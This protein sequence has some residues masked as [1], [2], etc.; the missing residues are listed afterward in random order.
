MIVSRR[1]GLALMEAM[2]VIALLAILTTIILP[3]YKGHVARSK[4]TGC[5]SNEKIISTLLNQYYIE[6]KKFPP[7]EPPDR[8]DIS[9][10]AAYNADK[11][12]F[13]CPETGNYYIYVMDEESENFTVMCRP[14]NG[15]PSHPLPGLPAL[16]PQYTRAGLRTS[17]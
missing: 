8:L 15:R 9:R 13:V 5:I 11:K 6:Y 17:P 4:L 1:R 16:Y 14:Q 10:F 7:P 2:V 3:I 12:N